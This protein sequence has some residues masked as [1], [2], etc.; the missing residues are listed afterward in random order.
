MLLLTRPLQALCIAVDFAASEMIRFIDQLF[1][2][3][4]IS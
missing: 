1:L 4:N 3:R 2:H